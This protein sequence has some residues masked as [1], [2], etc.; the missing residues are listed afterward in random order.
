MTYLSHFGVYGI[1][2]KGGKLLC[3][4]KNR[5]PYKNRYDLPGGSQESGESLLE[6]LRES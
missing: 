2:I 3:V 6:H 4:R 1:C 5:G